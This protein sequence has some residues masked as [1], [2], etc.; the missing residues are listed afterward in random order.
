MK[1]GILSLLWSYLYSRVKFH[2]AYPNNI[3]NYSCLFKL[4]D[5]PP[6]PRAYKVPG[7]SA[8]HLRLAELKVGFFSIRP[9]F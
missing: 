5:F 1:G 4:N 2:P 9:I 7:Q 8:D 6:P 3:A